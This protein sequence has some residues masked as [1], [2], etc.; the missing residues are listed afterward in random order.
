[1]DKKLYKSNSNRMISGVCGGMGEYFNI[2]A[3]LVR[4]VWVLVALLYGFGILAY[5]I[6]ILIIPKNTDY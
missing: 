5:L 4:I 2:D 3:T 6:C 1:M